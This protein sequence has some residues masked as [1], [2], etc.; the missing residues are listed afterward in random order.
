MFRLKL[1]LMTLLLVGTLFTWG[2]N[3][4][5]LENDNQKQFEYAGDEYQPGPF[6]SDENS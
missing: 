1:L 5:S 3:I 2:I 6:G 4:I